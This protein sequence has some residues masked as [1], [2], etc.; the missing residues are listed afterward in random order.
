METIGEIERKGTFR[1]ID[2]VAF[3]GVDKDFVGEKIK[4]KFFDVDFFASTKPSGS[5]L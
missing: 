3:W 2:D 4:F 1:K 5:G